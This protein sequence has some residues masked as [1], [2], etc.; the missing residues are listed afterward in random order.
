MPCAPFTFALGGSRKVAAV[1]R[2]IA[3]SLK[4]SAHILSA[5]GV[6]RYKLHAARDVAALKAPNQHVIS[7]FCAA[8]V[9]VKANALPSASRQQLAPSI[10]SPRNSFSV[11]VT[12]VVNQQPHFILQGA[13]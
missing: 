7:A 13:A 12:L 6:C 1:P 2:H 10:G 3:S 4:R 8:E 9:V 11:Q 5:H